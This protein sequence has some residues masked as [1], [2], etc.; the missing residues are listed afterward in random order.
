MQVKPTGRHHFTPS[1]MAIMTDTFRA[2]EDV[3]RLVPSQQ[4]WEC[5]ILQLM[6]K[7]SG[8]SSRS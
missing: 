7:Q 8:S 2:G 4:W 1:R 6:S 5:K 3:E